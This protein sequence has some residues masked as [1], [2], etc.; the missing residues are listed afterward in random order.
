MTAD[1]STPTTS[2]YRDALNRLKP[3]QIDEKQDSNRENKARAV[4]LLVGNSHEPPVVYRDVCTRGL[5]EKR[6]LPTPDGVDL[7]LTTAIADFNFDGRNEILL[8]KFSKVF[9][10]II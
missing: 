7:L 1:Q 5:N 9:F 3:I 8:G 4:H 10:L 2:S 6:V